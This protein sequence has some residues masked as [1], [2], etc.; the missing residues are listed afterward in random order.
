MKGI[1]NFFKENFKFSHILGS[2]LSTIIGLFL[3]GLCVHS[4]YTEVASF[5]DTLPL[6]LLAGGAFLSKDNFTINKP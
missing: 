6:L 3:I 1:I 2:P 5:T 4:I